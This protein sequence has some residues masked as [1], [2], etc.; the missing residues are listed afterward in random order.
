MEC[1]NCHHWNE[2]EARFC[3]ECG[4]EITAEAGGPARVSVT[5]G[6][7]S[8]AATTPDDGASAV[9]NAVPEPPPQVLVPADV[10]A[11]AP[12]TGP[13]LI[14]DKTGTIFKLGDATVIGR[15][16]PTVQI[17]FDGYED[18]KY[19]SHRHAQESTFYIEDLGSTNATRVNGVKLA[20]NQAQPLKDGDKV[21]FGKIEL[22][23]H[24]S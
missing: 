21:R 19:V 23:F 4:F 12:Y 20:A 7:G 16:E 13:R 11:P 9:Q 10:A 2:A 24:Q 14:S 3:E 1:P 6:V 17:D 15:E 8:P 22:T 5:G 18:G